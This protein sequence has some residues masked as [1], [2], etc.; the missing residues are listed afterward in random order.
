GG[1]E[2]GPTGPHHENGCLRTLENTRE[3][4]V[5]VVAAALRDRPSVAESGEDHEREVERR[6]GEDQRR[7]G[8][9]PAGGRTLHGHERGSA[10]TIPQEQAARVPEEDARPGEV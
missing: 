4:M 8:A 9:S 6:V 7:A 5:G 3:S 1:A 10:E 2:G